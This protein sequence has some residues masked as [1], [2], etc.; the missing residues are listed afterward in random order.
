M[1]CP[2]L[3]HCQVWG[4]T[5][6]QIFP[7]KIPFARCSSHFSCC[8]TTINRQQTKGRDR[9]VSYPITETQLLVCAFEVVAG[10]VVLALHFDASVVVQIIGVTVPVTHETRDETGS[11]CQ[12]LTV[13]GSGSG[14]AGR[15][16]GSMEA[17]RAALPVS[18]SPAAY[19]RS[20]P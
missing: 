5:E 12:S 10:F 6:A 7:G 9:R 3:F 2:Q 18:S 1:L 4:L 8:E 17:L 15:T 14:T 16:V 13:F 11:G 19:R 20:A